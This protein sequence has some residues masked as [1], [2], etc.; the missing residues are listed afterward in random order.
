MASRVTEVIIP[1]YPALIRFQCVCGVLCPSL[2]PPK[3]E[4]CGAFSFAIQRDLNRLKKW[5]WVNLMRFNI[6]KSK[7]LHLG[8]RNPRH[9]YRL[10]GIVLESSTAE[11][12][13]GVLVD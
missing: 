6:A 9:I 8:Q 12:D 3:Q 1:L 5:A 13:L 10:E 4:G 2:G 7:V 11:K